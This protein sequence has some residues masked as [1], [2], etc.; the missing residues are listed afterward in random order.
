MILI[1][2]GIYDLIL[3]LSLMVTK[4]VHVE[5]GEVRPTESTRAVSPYGAIST[6]Y[7]NTGTPSAMQARFMD[8]VVLLQ[9]R[10]FEPKSD[11]GSGSKPILRPSS[12]HFASIKDDKS[13]SGLGCPAPC[14]A[15]E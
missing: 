14:R 2:A 4:G 13:W 6:Q 15:E 3:N 1:R 9:S 7:T 12:I 10:L 8:G 5:D 11:S